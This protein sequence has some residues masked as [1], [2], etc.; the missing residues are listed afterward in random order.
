MPNIF[1]VWPRAEGKFVNS[2]TR[3]IKGD[4]LNLRC[5]KTNNAHVV[6]GKPE[7]P[8]VVKESVDT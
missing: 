7:S 2:W 8:L 6:T 5:L 1:L 3:A 4:T